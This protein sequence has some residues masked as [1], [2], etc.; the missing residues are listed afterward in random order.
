MCV[1]CPYN[2]LSFRGRCYFI[3]EELKSWT[4]SEEYCTSRQSHLVLIDDENEMNFIEA[5]GT[6]RSFVWIGLRFNGSSSEWTWLNGSTLRKGSI[7]MKSGEPGAICGSYSKKEIYPL[8]CTNTLKWICEKKAIQF[9]K[10]CFGSNQ[11]SKD[12]F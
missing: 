5:K 6:S 2:W 10:K 9:D 7:P 12:Q 3:S 11:L 4:S 1:I 8:K